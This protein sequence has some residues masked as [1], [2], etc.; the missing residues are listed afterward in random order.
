MRMCPAKNAKCF[1]CARIGH[2]ANLCLS[3]KQQL[4]FVEE[5][6]D[7][8]PYLLMIDAKC[9]TVSFPKP[10]VNATVQP[11]AVHNSSN[12]LFKADTGADVYILCKPTYVNIF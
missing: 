3:K 10:L 11:F 8:N 9:P 7:S 2:Y 1:S 6:G 5:M 4:N 12:V